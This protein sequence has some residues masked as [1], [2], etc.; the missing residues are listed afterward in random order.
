MLSLVEWNHF[1]KAW[2]RGSIPNLMVLFVQIRR[3]DDPRF[4]LARLLKEVPW[5]RTQNP[6]R[7]PADLSEIV[8]AARY[9]CTV[10][11]SKGNGI[12]AVRHNCACSFCLVLEII[13]KNVCT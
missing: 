2:Y 5:T 12:S 4:P 9:L 1:L 3:I 6:T 13:S 8:S 10:I 7:Y 11:V